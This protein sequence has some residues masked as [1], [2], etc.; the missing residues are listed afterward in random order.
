MAC[1]QADGPI[2]AARLTQLMLEA[3]AKHVALL[4][5]LRNAFNTLPRALM[6]TE[7]FAHPKLAGLWRIM[8]WIYGTASLLLIFKPDGSLAAWIFSCE[9]VRQGCVFGSFG[10]SIATLRLVVQLKVKHPS[11]LVVAIIDD[12]TLSG[13]PKQVC[14]AFVLFIELCRQNGLIVQ[15]EKCKLLVPTS[16]VSQELSS[17][18]GAHDLVLEEGCV[19]LLGTVVGR[20]ESK[21]AAWAA[22]KVASWD[23]P[24]RL[25]NTP[26]LSAQIALLLT[27]QLSTRSTF[28]ARAGTPDSSGPALKSF[29]VKVCDAVERRH[30]LQFAS[31]FSKALFQ[32]PM[33][34]G[35]AGFV[36]G[37]DPLSVAAAFASAMAV[38]MRFIPKTPLSS[39]PTGLLTE[40]SSFI[41][42]SICL[43]VL[44][45]AHMF[46]EKFLPKQVVYFVA[47]FKKASPKD[48]AH[49]QGKITKLLQDAYH[50][51]LKEQSSPAQQAVLNSRQ[52]PFAS[53]WMRAI[54]VSSEF[55]LSDQTVRFG[56]SLATSSLLPNLPAT[57]HCDSELTPE[58]LIS[59]KNAP[60][61]LLRHNLVVSSFVSI[62]AH[63]G[64]PSKQEPRCDY[65]DCKNAQR[66]DAVFFL[67]Q[68]AV[69]VDVSITSPVC[70]SNM[71]ATVKAGGSALL[72]R[73]SVKNV[74]YREKARL[75]GN[76]FRPLVFET[77]GRPGADVRAFLRML[78]SL[79][80]S[81][82][83]MP[84]SD[85]MMQLQ[86]QLLRGN[87]RMASSCIMR[88]RYHRA[89]GQD[90]RYLDLGE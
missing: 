73:E 47:I 16:G 26:A 64:V 82:P 80:G 31:P 66:P 21:K 63:H 88:A 1:S 78:T 11:V 87:S 86:L 17:F 62:A 54:P 28:L 48:T 34:Q 12:V 65:D 50:T 25:A 77:H 70:P 75:R 19:P 23:G 42:L 53:A 51:A 41:N 2:V 7:L 46:D 6:L 68:D 45:T 58:H 22:D 13:P 44:H 3:D 56:L 40:L 14:D 10:F 49:I 74:K 15:N 39:I 60:D 36:P 72:K 38:T 35:G 89:R 67:P 79:P 37:G 90:A 5:D 8:L 57:C 32:A 55:K 61:K 43:Q 69:E 24:L 30:D 76:S 18:A 52:H 85:C 83:S 9:G 4:T 84:V 71:L 81:S 59:C 20:D 33:R 27:R 29:D